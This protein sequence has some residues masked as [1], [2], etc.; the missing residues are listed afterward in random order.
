MGINDDFIDYLYVDPDY[1]RQGIGR[2]LIEHAHKLSPNHLWLY[3]HVVNTMARGFYGKNGF[4][5][6]KFGVSPP[7][8][9]EP[10]VEY[11]WR[12]ASP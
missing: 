7:P 8:E 2:A 6:L 4:V 3:T 11:H 9:L 5:A 1:Y 10:D 12:S